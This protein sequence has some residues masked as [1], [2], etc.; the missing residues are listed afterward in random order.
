MK[1]TFEVMK[2][3]NPLI[4]SVALCLLTF[5]CKQTK[6][7]NVA[8][9]LG[10][11]DSLYS[12]ILKEERKIW[13][14]VP[15]S[16]TP[17]NYL[18]QHYPVLYLL[19]GDAHFSAVASMLQH[20]SGNQICPEMIVVAIPNT[21]R[22]RD[23][24]PT[25]SL[26]LPD[27]KPQDFLKTT[28]GGEMFTQFMEKELIP[29][30][31][32]HYPTA[33]N[34]TLVGHS[35][36]GLF[37][38]NALMHHSQ[39]FDSYVAIDPSMWWDKQRLLNFADTAL[40]K[41]HFTRKALFLS[42]ANTM[43]KG[44]DTARVVKDTAGNSFHIRSILHLAKE[45]DSNPDNGLRFEWKYYGKDDHGSVPFISEYDA[46]RFIFDYYKP[47]FDGDNITAAKINQHFK[48]VS[49]KIGYSMMPPEQMINGMG[50]GSLQQKKWEQ[51]YELFNMNIENYPKSP[52]TFDSMG[53]YF[54]AKGDSSKA[55]EMFA[56][57]L[58]LQETPGTR[59]KLV[60]LNKK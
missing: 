26:L 23:L 27:G 6:E 36:G 40:K 52:N 47:D 21:D 20:L 28:G 54:L 16:G 48:A 51:A 9:T 8:V 43:Q 3:K 15:N 2:M 4:I 22:S 50:Y 19:D 11:R 35:F 60:G 59:K 5:A 29:Y 49:G 14:Y 32:S 46:L 30:I 1:S 42:V 18:P 56:K 37:A 13:V 57:S 7:Y 45:I 24:T 58:S 38:I 10:I 34:R 39:L 17:S 44:M 25:H 41:E 33:P 53:D 12:T 31:E 55:A